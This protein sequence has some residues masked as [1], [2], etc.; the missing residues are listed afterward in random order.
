MLDHL[1]LMSANLMTLPHFSVS[2]A[3]KLPKSAGNPG[4]SEAHDA[5]RERA[6]CSC[7]A[8]HTFKSAQVLMRC[9]SCGRV[10]SAVHL[11]PINAVVANKISSPISRGSDT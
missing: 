11:A 8:G 9:L 1:G 2:L 3:I 10:S 5:S 4:N 7:S 6:G